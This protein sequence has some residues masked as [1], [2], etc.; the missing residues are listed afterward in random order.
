MARNNAPGPFDRRNPVDY[1]ETRFDKA[2]LGKG[3]AGDSLLENVHGPH[4][5]RYEAV[6]EADLHGAGRA[7]VTTMG[8]AVDEGVDADDGRGGRDRPGWGSPAS[9]M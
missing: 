6:A 5:P 3:T 9:G 1:R 7:V 4:A 2:W 8:L